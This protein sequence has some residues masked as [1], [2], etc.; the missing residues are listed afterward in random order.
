MERKLNIFGHISRMSDDRLIKTVVFGMMDG[1]SRRGRSA[2]DI[3]DIQDWC[4]AC[5]HD[6]NTL[7]Q[8]RSDWQQMICGCM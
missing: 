5:V 3:T 4:G 8:N 7:V 6:L 2:R 1:T